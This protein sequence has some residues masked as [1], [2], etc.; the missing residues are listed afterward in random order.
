MITTL[1]D[2]VSDAL[3]THIA[4]ALELDGSGIEVVEVADG[5]ASVRLSGVCSGCPA[6][7]MTIITQLEQELKRH[8]P[9]IEFLEAVP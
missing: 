9:E 1:K 8:V 5:I 7:I 6:T 3:K 2:R 4:P